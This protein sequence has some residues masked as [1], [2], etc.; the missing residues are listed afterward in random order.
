[1]KLLLIISLLCCTAVTAQEKTSPQF[2]LNGF[3]K[4]EKGKAVSLATVSVY[5]MADSVLLTATATDDK[6]KFSI[7]INAGS[8]DL[9]ISFLSFQQKK[10]SNVVVVDKNINLGTIVLQ[11]TVKQMAEILVTSDKKMMELKLDKRIYNVS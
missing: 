11:E 3:V 9:V 2:S 10:I 7:D 4:D 8:Y 1:M 6:G 5:K